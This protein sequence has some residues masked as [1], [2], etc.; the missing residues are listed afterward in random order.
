MCTKHM[1][2]IPIANQQTNETIYA[3]EYAYTKLELP[4][5]T[6]QIVI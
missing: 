6:Q 2:P 5:T 3:N 1:E 4:T